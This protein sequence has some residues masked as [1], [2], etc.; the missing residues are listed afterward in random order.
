MDK[1]E[2]RAKKIIRREQF[3]Y[4]STFEFEYDSGDYQT[5]LDKVLQAVDYEGLRA[6]QAVN[7]ADPDCPTLMGIGLVSFTEVVGAGPSK[8]CDILGFGM[9]DSY[10]ILMHPTGSVIAR[11]RTIFQG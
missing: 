4:T 5:V 8:I 1:A 3:P 2:I 9:F 11:M 7:R 10:E 6:E